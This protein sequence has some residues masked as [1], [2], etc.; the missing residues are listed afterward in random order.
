[1]RRMGCFKQFDRFIIFV[2]NENE[3]E[4]EIAMPDL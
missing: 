2:I 4:N 3:N 1:M